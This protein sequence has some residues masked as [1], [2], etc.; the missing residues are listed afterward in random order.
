MFIKML[1][2]MDK[3]YRHRKLANNHFDQKNKIDVHLF[4]E[5]IFL[6]VVTVNDHTT[7]VAIRLCRG[8]V[9]ALQK[10]RLACLVREHCTD[11]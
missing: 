2:N 10:E 6:G 1:G 9:I 5:Q 7:T 11:N 4:L 8:F 3:L